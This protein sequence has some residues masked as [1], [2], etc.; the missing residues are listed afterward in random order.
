MGFGP[1]IATLGVSSME[2]SLSFYTEVLGF[3]LNWAWSDEA[4]FDE[5][6]TP[7]FACIGCGEACLFLSQNG[8]SEKAW[9]FVEI[10][11]VEEVDA[12]S[13]RLK[14]RVEVV[15]PLND[16]P[17]GSREFS[18]R[19]PDGHILRF[20]CPLDRKRAAA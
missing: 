8:G 7:E 1:I 13:A 20:S 3:S 14:D 11:F 6:A 9:L 5:A 4:R 15:E 12:L 2:V 10:P 18:V 16:Q 19:D 17:W